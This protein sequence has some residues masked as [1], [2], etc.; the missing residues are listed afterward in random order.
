[1]ASGLSVYYANRLLQKALGQADF[2][3]PT[4]MWVALFTDVGAAAYLRANN[5]AAATEVSGNNYSRVEIL[6]ATGITFA[7][8]TVGTTNQNS[9]VVFPAASGPWGTI[10]ASA[11]MDA[12][13]LGNVLFYDDW[14]TPTVV[15]SPDA[16]RIPANNLIITF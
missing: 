16:P 7:T 15:T 12:A 11:L 14:D 8:P 9:D 4:S 10:Y 6:G 3:P 13:T 1:M 5:R 2:V